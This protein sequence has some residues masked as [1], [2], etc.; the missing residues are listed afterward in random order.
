[1]EDAVLATKDGPAG[2]ANGLSAGRSVYMGRAW[3]RTCATA[4][5]GGGAQ[6][7]HMPY[8]SRSHI[9]PT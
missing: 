2:A 5:K 3:L 8:A 6:I 7:V 9:P 4:T 1:M